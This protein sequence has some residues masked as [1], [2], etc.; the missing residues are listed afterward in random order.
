V[1]DPVKV[2]I[3]NYPE[4]QTETLL[5]DN[6]PEDP[7]GGQ[8]SVPFSREILIE[9]DDFMENPSK[10]YFRLAPGQMVRLKSA[11]IIQC[12]D[13]RKDESGNITELHCR[14]F[15]ESK[16]GEDTSGLHVKGTLHWVNAKD[17]VEVEV[18]EYDRLFKVEDPASEE[19]DFKSYINPDSLKTVKGYAEPAILE[20]TNADRFQF[21]RKGYYCIDKESSKNALVFNRTVTLKDSWSKEVKK[22]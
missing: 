22:G 6:N 20:A 12:E 10:K 11:Y 1:F 15:P 19:G 9:R 2:I 16:S 13:V 8:R 3:T 18:R 14:Y 7:N 4:G 17:A 5:S 21:L